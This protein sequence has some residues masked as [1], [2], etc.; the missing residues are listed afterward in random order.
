MTWKFKNRWP[1][2]VKLHQIEPYRR[3]PVILP[4]KSWGITRNLQS[5]INTGYICEVF[6]KPKD[7]PHC[8]HWILHGKGMMATTIYYFGNPD[9]YL[10]MKFD[11]PEGKFDRKIRRRI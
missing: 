3:K 10:K 6:L 8:I 4:Q 9:A 1:F 2:I 5:A 7:L 11:L